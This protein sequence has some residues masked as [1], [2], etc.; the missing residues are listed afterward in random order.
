MLICE[1]MYKYLNV[2]IIGLGFGNGN[3]N[4]VRINLQ[5]LC[6]RTKAKF[7]VSSV[8]EDL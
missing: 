8:K 5:R 1:N 6:V 2:T 4:K 7:S 3:V